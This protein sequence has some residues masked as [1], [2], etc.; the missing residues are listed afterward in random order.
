MSS[1]YPQMLQGAGITENHTRLL[2]T[3]CQNVVSFG[4]AVVGAICT[5][6]GGR[7]LQFLVSTG[8]HRWYN[9]HYQ[10]INGT[11]IYAASDGTILAKSSA[12]SLELREWD[13]QLL[14]QYRPVLQYLCHGQCIYGCRLEMLF[15]IHILGYVWARFIYYPFVVSVPDSQSTTSYFECLAR[16][17]SWGIVAAP[18]TTSVGTDFEIL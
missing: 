1:Y 3:G 14:D 17:N 5:D 12:T 18:T 15:P 10:A 2:Y 6:K 11:N 9:L 16:F 7:R 13:F 4:G 8:N